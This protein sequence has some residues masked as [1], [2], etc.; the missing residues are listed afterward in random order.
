MTKFNG[1]ELIQPERGALGFA[2]VS[3]ALVNAAC[4]YFFKPRGMSPGCQNNDFR[5]RTR[6][7]ARI[8][9][10]KVVRVKRSELS[11]A[12]SKFENRESKIR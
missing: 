9:R 3:G 7:E 4:D 2:R 1:T 12:K 11:R 6:S 8:H 5:S 10:A